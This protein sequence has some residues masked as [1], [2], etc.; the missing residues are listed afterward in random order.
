M[1]F[2]YQNAVLNVPGAVVPLLPS[3][4]ARDL[5]VLL[6]LCASETPEQAAQRLQLPQAEVTAAIS[7]WQA[8][9]ILTASPDSCSQARSAPAL[10]ETVHA[11]DAQMPQTAQTLQTP[12]SPATSPDAPKRGIPRNDEIPNYTGAA[13]AALLNQN[14]GAIKT[15]I[16]QCQEL[17]GKIFNVTEIRRLV[18]LCDLYGLDAPYVLTVYAYCKKKGKTSV[19]YVEKTAM[20]LFAEQ[21]DT[22][23]K[24]EAYLQARSAADTLEPTLRRLLGLGERALTANEANAVLEIARLP[25]RGN[26]L[27]LAYDS[28]M[29][30][31]SRPS[32]S[33][34]YRILKRWQDAGL[35]DEA[36]ILREQAA[37]REKQQA[38]HEK[39]PRVKSADKRGA[40]APSFVVDDFFAA[41]MAR[42]YDSLRKEATPAAETEKSSETAPKNG[43]DRFEN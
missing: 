10:A 26:L 7:F 3:A 6:A 37:F 19:A 5:R 20:S 22:L 8:A 33:Y 15:M 16:E 32:L 18:A 2:H 30:S 40:S 23:P 27:K 9:G 21:I 12:T 41:A 39:K 1:K 14:G 17:A 29:Q 36:E 13:L 24:L 25:Y 31:V 42:S 43:P 28:M 11:S 38:A 4:S 34:L 35:S